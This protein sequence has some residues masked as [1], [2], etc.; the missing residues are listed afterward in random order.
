MTM[1]ETNPPV[2]KQVFVASSTTC[3]PCYALKSRLNK[4][5]IEVEIKYF[6]DNLELFK[7]HQIKTVPQLVILE[8]SEVTKIQGQDDIVKYLKDNH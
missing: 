4:E 8:N 3:G 6:E 2:D 7:E 5:G 1:E